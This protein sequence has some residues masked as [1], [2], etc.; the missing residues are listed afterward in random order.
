MISA[1]N[2]GDEIHMMYF[3]TETR[4]KIKEKKKNRKK[5]QNRK[6]RKCMYV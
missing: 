6:E 4:G 1:I 3:V 2:D 5:E